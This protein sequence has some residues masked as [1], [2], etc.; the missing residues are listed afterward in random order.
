MLRCSMILKTRC[1]NL[2]FRLLILI[3]GSILLDATML[4]SAYAVGSTTYDILRQM[5]SAFVIV[6]T[7][8]IVIGIALIVGGLMRLKRY[9]EQRANNGG[10][11]G[12]SG[13]IISLLVGTGLCSLPTILSILMVSVWGTA[14]PDESLMADV[15]TTLTPIIIL[16]R[17]IGVVTIVRGLLQ[18][19]RHSG[20]EMQQSQ[21]VIG[22]AIML[23]IIGILLAHILTT[24]AVVNNIFGNLL[25][26]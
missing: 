14:S 21:G 24:A 5:E 4:T 18:L 7:V 6:E 9:G 23:I 10:Q 12:A 16:V 15:S 19:T 3:V 25:S 20:G 22:K 13:P 17:L 1:T 26:F 2:M 8:C 11:A